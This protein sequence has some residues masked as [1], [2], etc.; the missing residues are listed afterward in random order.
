MSENF[1][2]DIADQLRNQTPP[3]APTAVEPT[4]AEPT[5]AP[6]AAEPTPDEPVVAA[7]VNPI[8]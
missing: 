6:V 2:S 7:P 4:P 1:L 3:V 5:P 8:A